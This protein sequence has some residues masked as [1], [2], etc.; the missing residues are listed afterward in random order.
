MSKTSKFIKWLLIDNLELDF[1]IPL[2][3]TI[4]GILLIYYYVP[5]YRTIFTVI[6][7]SFVIYVT[8]KV[9]KRI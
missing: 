1:I 6:W 2:I 3:I 8:Y 5:V 7:I 4:A 9:I